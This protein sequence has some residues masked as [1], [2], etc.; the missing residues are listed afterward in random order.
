[1]IELKAKD[2]TFGGI[3][4]FHTMQDCN[5]FLYVFKD[6]WCNVPWENPKEVSDDF[7]ISESQRKSMDKPPK[8]RAESNLSWGFSL[9]KRLGIDLTESQNLFVKGMV[10]R[11]S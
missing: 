1:M 2:L 11:L 4:Y 9:V 10:E 3:F 7:K 5:D 8:E 6:H